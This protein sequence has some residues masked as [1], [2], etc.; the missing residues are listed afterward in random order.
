M[1]KFNH[2]VALATETK[3]SWSNIDQAR[4]HFMNPN[5]LWAEKVASDA[6]V[7][8]LVDLG[9]ANYGVIIAY[10]SGNLFAMLGLLKLCESGRVNGIE[11][12]VVLEM[13]R[14]DIAKANQF[15]A[16]HQ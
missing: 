15:V 2:I 14:A 7:A 11:L 5:G 16:E 9:K 1:A 4:F 8:E 10:G 12:S 13:L 3:A 6:Q